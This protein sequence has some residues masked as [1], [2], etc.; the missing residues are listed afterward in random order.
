MIFPIKN[1]S[2]FKC[3]PIFVEGAYGGYKLIETYCCEETVNIHIVMKEIKHS[4]G[5]A[6]EVTSLSVF[7]PNNDGDGGCDYCGEYIMSGD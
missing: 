5:T 7:C 3:W 1:N 2:R 6:L 4:S